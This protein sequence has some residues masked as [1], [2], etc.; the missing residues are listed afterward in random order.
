MDH[1]LTCCFMTEFVLTVDLYRL[2]KL[3]TVDEFTW[4]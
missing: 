1:V 2:I 4:R 3:L